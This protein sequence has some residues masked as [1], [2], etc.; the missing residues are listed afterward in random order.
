[1]K[2]PVPAQ[3]GVALCRCGFILIDDRASEWG[4]KIESDLLVCGQFEPLQH[5][6]DT[7]DHQGRVHVGRANEGA[8][9]HCDD[10]SLC[11][12]CGAVPC[13]PECGGFE[14]RFMQLVEDQYRREPNAKILG[15]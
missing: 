4:N 8:W 7:I 2:K 13:P 10:K 11:A 14:K 3:A 6:H 9:C 1:V 5:R 12:A 15:I